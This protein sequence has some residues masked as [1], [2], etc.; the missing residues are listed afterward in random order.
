M[1]DP[2]DQQSTNRAGTTQ[3][4]PVCQKSWARHFPAAS[5]SKGPSPPHPPPTAGQ[6]RGATNR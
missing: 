1:T 6:R 2:S 3:H 4:R 5:L